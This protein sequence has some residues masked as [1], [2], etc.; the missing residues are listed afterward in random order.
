M[1]TSA[2]MFINMVIFSYKSVEV[3][4][5]YRGEKR[6]GREWVSYT[7]DSFLCCTS[8]FARPLTPRSG[9]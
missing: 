7:K 2:K 3:G 6:N 8:D 5:S 4:N 9:V 1:Q